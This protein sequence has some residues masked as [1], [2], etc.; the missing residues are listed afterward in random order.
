MG[1]QG[2]KLRR[3]GIDQ[4]GNRV[5]LE[6][7]RPVANQQAERLA[8]DQRLLRLEA[9]LTMKRGFVHTS[10]RR[11]ELETANM[12]LA[13]RRYNNCVELLTTDQELLTAFRSRPS[14]RGACVANRRASGP[15]KSPFPLKS[16]AKTAV[17]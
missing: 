17:N 14:P 16:L 11:A 8:A 4:E 7:G 6:P 1:A 15:K 2:S 5:G 3:P 12:G 13:A 10:P 9:R